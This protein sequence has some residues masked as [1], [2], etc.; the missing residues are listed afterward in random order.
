MKC[1]KCNSEKLTIVKS[2]PHNKLVCSECLAFQK[3]LSTKDA[4][5]F[6]Q[7][8]HLKGVQP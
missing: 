4:D 8:E 1:V 6:L 3:F 2:G 7:I 5:T